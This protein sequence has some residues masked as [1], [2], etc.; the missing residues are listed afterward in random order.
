MSSTERT[1]RSSR[2]STA[3]ILAARWRSMA[4]S[5][6][7]PEPPATGSSGPPVLHAP[8]EVAGERRP[9]LERVA[10]A[11]H[12]GQVRRDLAVFKPLHSQLRHRF[13]G[14]RGDRVKALCLIPVLG[15]KAD[16]D[17]VAGD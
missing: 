9:Q 10:N 3:L 7:R 12:L 2:A 11:Q 6:T 5:G 14:R 1:D 8:D 13:L 15:R 17:V 4:I 16:V